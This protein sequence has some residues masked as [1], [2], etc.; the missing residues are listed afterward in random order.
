MSFISNQ[1]YLPDPLFWLSQ[2]NYRTFNV[3]VAKLLGI[4]A[5][6]F[7]SE[8]A[9]KQK[10]YH[11]IGQLR[12]DGFFYFTLADAEERTCLTR[13]QQDKA[14][15][16]LV[17]NKLIEKRIMGNPAT[18]Y[19]RV[20]SE[21]INQMFFVPKIQK[22][23]LHHVSA[24]MGKSYN[25]ECG[26]VTN[27]NV[28]KLQTL[29]YM[30][31]KKEQHK[32]VIIAQPQQIAPAAGNNNFSPKKPEKTEKPEDPIH[33]CLTKTDEFTDHQK[34]ML[35]KK[36]AEA[37]EDL[38]KWYAYINH[39]EGPGSKLT[40]DNAKVKYLQAIARHPESFKDA[41]D[42]LG[43]P[44]LTKAAQEAKEAEKKRSDN[45]KMI[46]KHKKLVENFQHRQVYSGW[47]V[48]KL[49]DHICFR[50]TGEYAPHS[51]YFIDSTFPQ[52][53]ARLLKKLGVDIPPNV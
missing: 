41:I 31:N 3:E 25:L 52:Q 38:A 16:V 36:F 26:K 46:D 10:Y 23:H 34:K 11:K 6:I 44:K 40:G 13:D 29:I 51:L 48:E 4:Y 12:P 18:R 49:S 42:N 2:D 45:V 8:L 21:A 37:N 24:N 50:R 28:G 39:P 47:K 30:N 15:S 53:L 27:Q 7:L 5:A 43:Q 14:I 33:P 32:E 17:E 22:M 19:F 20:D 9:S 1:N 35:T